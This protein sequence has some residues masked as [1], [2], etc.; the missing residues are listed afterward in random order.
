MI[1]LF[2]ITIKECFQYDFSNMI[3][4]ITYDSK[5]SDDSS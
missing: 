5:L 1:F 3:S 2:I 4:I